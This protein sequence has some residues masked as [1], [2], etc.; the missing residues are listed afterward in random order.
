MEYVYL[1]RSG[2]DAK[3]RYVGLTSDLKVHNAGQSPHTTKGRPWHLVVYLAFTESRKA[4]KF[5][6][7]LKQGFGHAFANR[8]FW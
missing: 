7:Y 1:L 3:L 5:E 4:R 6:R 2:S 8:H